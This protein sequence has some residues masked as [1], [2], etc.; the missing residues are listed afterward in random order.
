[1][2]LDFLDARLMETHP[3]HSKAMAILD[4]KNLV[5]PGSLG[6]S[7]QDL[8]MWSITM[9]IL[10]PH[11]GRATSDPFQMAERLMAEIHGG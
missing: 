3:F 10:S 7:S 9:V 6:G 2:Y 5:D 4:I 1:V 11:I 8:D